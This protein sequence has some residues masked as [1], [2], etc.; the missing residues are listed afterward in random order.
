MV[1]FL[2]E[3]M[4]LIVMVEYGQYFHGGKSILGTRN[5]GAAT[6]NKFCNMRD[7]ITIHTA[8]EGL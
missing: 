2:Y 3:N 5:A 7:N 6:G 8:Y 1:P 4:G